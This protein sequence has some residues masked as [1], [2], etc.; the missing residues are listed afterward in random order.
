[1]FW[2]KDSTAS[3]RCPKTN[4][5]AILARIAV[6]PAANPATCDNA[7]L[8][9]VLAAAISSRKPLAEAVTNPIAAGRINCSALATDCCMIS[10]FSSCPI[11]VFI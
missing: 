11:L 7:A 6:I 8:A 2:A 5:V 10:G 4:K 3:I 9:V 1:V